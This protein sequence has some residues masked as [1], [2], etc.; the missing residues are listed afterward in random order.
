MVSTST[1]LL[2]RAKSRDETAWQEFVTLYSPLIYAWCRRAG[3]SG[4]DAA[5]V[6]QEVFRVLWG[7]LPHFDPHK[8]S[9]RGWLKTIT[10]NKIRDLYRQQQRGWTAAGGTSNDQQI[11]N[12]PAPW[13]AVEDDPEIDQQRLSRRALELVKAEFEERTWKAFWLV[14]VEDRD[15]ASVA[16]ELKMN[17]MAVYKAKSRVLKKLREK[18]TDLS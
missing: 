6:L 18:L 5:D 3:L 1:S 12:V 7:G 15:P 13:T 9:F 16:D 2:A 10:A 4:E 8:G 17:R 14:T 11:Q